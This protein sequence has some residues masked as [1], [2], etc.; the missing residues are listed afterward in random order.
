MDEREI[1][2]KCL[3]LAVEAAKFPDF[4]RDPV[5]VANQSEQF[6]NAVVK[7][8]TSSEKSNTLGLKKPTA[9]ESGTSRR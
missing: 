1:R 2:L 5:G 7:T 8:P 9:P 4:P 6:Y 3:E